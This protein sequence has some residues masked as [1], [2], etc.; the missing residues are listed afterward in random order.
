MI[1]R[2]VAESS[3]LGA[4]REELYN[5]LAA[6]SD[7]IKGLAWRNENDHSEGF[8]AYYDA[9]KT[10]FCAYFC[11]NNNVPSEV[12][13]NQNGGS[14]Y[15]GNFHFVMFP[16]SETYGIGTGYNSNKPDTT[17]IY[18]T[19]FIET[20]TAF[21]LISYL[22]Y[23]ATIT[24]RGGQYFI[25]TKNHGCAINYSF[26]SSWSRRFAFKGDF[27]EVYMSQSTYDTNLTCFAPLCGRSQSVPNNQIYFTPFTS[28]PDYPCIIDSDIGKYATDGYFAIAESIEEID[29]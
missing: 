14:Q 10:D 9:E 21:M 7:V 3:T 8:E 24:S 27:T 29:E 5:W 22:T 17:S 28:T 15:F 13:Y 23:N 26:G 19:F 4:L 16:F 1:K 20:D 12:S 2:Y 25:V 18:K 11:V 6:N